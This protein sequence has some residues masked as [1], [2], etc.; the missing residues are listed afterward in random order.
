MSLIF[1]DFKNGAYSTGVGRGFTIPKTIRNGQQRATLKGVRRCF[2]SSLATQ[3][4]GERCGMAQYSPLNSGSR[5]LH[6][7]EL[8]FPPG[9]RSSW[10]SLVGKPE[11]Y[12][13]EA[14]GAATVLIKQGGKYRII[15]LSSWNL[16]VHL[17]ATHGFT[18]EE[19][20]RFSCWQ[21]VVGLPIAQVIDNLKRY[22]GAMNALC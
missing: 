19:S 13:D 15:L 11:I 17:V 8:T 5:I 2:I 16:A 20:L 18:A 10:A 4:V 9:T 21:P 22:K 1:Y 3:I 14:T 7:Y 6:D 12:K